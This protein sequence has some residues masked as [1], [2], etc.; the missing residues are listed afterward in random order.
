MRGRSVVVRVGSRLGGLV[1]ASARLNSKPAWVTLS[2]LAAER[3]TL[4]LLWPLLGN[5]MAY[6]GEVQN[7]LIRQLETGGKD[8][9]EGCEPARRWGQWKSREVRRGPKAS[10]RYRASH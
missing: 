6:V 8:C 5:W 10:Q 7:R 9:N 2:V 1:R 4:V 3:S